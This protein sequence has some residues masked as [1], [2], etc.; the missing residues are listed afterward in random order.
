MRSQAK[1]KKRNLGLLGGEGI[2]EGDQENY[3]KQGLSSKVC[4]SVT[5]LNLEFA[6]SGMG[7]GDNSTNVNFIYKCQF[8]LQERFRALPVS[9]SSQW[10]LAQNKTNSKEV[11]FGVG[12]S[13]TLQ[14]EG[15]TSRARVLWGQQ[16]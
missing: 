12:Y 1:Q 6:S 7:E 2:G 9:A 3:G 10:S 11:Y 5:S 4:Q 13:G 16:A 8:P 15:R 14:N